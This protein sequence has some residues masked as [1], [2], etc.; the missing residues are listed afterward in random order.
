[1]QSFVSSFTKISNNNKSIYDCYN[2]KSDLGIEEKIYK[3]VSPEN[4]ISAPIYDNYESFNE[5]FQTHVLLSFIL[6]DIELDHSE[7]ELVEIS[8]CDEVFALPPFSSL[9][10]Q[11]EISKG[12]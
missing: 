12:I 3:V 4:F 11:A 10:L 6:E 1:V 2:T 8:Q 9:E 5:E 7:Q